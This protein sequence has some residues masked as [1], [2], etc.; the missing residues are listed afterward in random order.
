MEP[1]ERVESVDEHLNDTRYNADPG[2]LELIATLPARYYP[3][4]RRSLQMRVRK[5]LIHFATSPASS[6]DGDISR[7]S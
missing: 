5:V 1:K 7:P 2:E 3:R 4:E 6:A